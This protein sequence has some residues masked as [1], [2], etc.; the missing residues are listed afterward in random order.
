M[1]MWQIKLPQT[2]RIVLQ[3]LKS[4][5]LFEFIPT[6]SFKSQLKELLGVEDESPQVIDDDSSSSCGANGSEEDSVT[7]KSGIERVGTPSLIDN[8]GAMLLIGL[9]ICLLL[10]IL[11]LLRICT[12]RSPC[13]R[14]VY[15]A[16][17]KKLFYNTLLRFVL[18]STLKLQI[19][20]STVLAYD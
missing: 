14:R 9:L 13:A 20:A 7:E 12:K 6:E 19:A 2:T 11:L 8:M 3:G 5:A 4:I 1:Q 18:Q 16:I 15:E 10:L 17:K